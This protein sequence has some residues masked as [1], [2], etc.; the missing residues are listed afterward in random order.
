M[1]SSACWTNANFTH[2]SFHAEWIWIFLACPSI[3][4]TYEF[5][6]YVSLCL[7][8]IDWTN[9]TYSSLNIDQ[10]RILPARYFILNRYEFFLRDSHIE[11]I[12]IFLTSLLFDGCFY[13]LELQYWL[14]VN[15]VYV[16]FHIEWMRISPICPSILNEYEFWWRLQFFCNGWFILTRAAILIR[17]EFYLYAIPYLMRENF[18]W[19]SFHF[20]EWMLILPYV[21][22]YWMDVF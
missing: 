3:L 5:C 12:R 6:L 22:P 8:L 13:L 4:D 9:F 19:L 14:E 20:I 21:I 18:A 15:F 1:C 10:M 11:W 7:L 17:C 16:S 2:V